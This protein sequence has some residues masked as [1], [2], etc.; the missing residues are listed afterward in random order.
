MRNGLFGV[1]LAA[2]QVDPHD[3]VAVR[4]ITD[5]RGALVELLVG[6]AEHED[7]FVQP[8]LERFAPA[9]AEAIADTHPRLEAQIAEL[10]LL[11]DRAAEPCPE[12]ARILTHRLSLGLTWFTAEHLQHQEFE[13]FE[14]MVMLSQYV[15]ADELRTID[16]AIV[17][18]IPPEQMAKAAA[19][20]LPAMNVEDQTE[21]YAGA[22]AGA[23][24]EVFQG[25]L[26]LAETVLEPERYQSL[27]TRLAV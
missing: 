18:S 22:R 23:P 6:H 2:G 7:V 8:V 17:A 16:H 9:H 1:T 13:E 19:Y 25:M 20:M 24:P 21:L 15:S 12:Q 5:R 14:A 3:S 11:A 10:E 27:R 4:G 26:V